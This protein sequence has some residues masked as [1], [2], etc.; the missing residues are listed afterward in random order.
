MEV[1]L[2]NQWV[3][4]AAAWKQ[5]LS[6]L[7]INREYAKA[8]RRYG[9]QIGLPDAEM[10]DFLRW[11][12]VELLSHNQTESTKASKA[13]KEPLPDLV[14]SDLDL[15]EHDKAY[16]HDTTRNVYVVHLPSRKHPLAIPG[17]T[18][19]AIR[20][21]YS[22]WSGSPASINEIARKFGMARRTVVELLRVMGTTHDSA[23]WTEET[24]KVEGEQVL[25]EDLLRRKEERI[26]VAS[27]RASWNAVKDDAN[28]WRNLR[29]HVLDKLAT[30]TPKSYKVRKL[31]LPQS[32]REYV[33]IVSPTDF[34]FGKYADDFEV[35]MEDNRNLQRQRLLVSTQ[36]VMGDVVLFGRPE[37][38]IVGV[39]SDFFNIDND[40]KS[41]TEGT[42]QDVDGNPAEIMVQ[43][44]RLMVEYIDTLRQIA[45]VQLVLMSGN[46]DRMMGT[47]M[48][49]YLE[50]WYRGQT[51]VMVRV[52]S[53]SPR[54]YIEYGNNLL[55]FHH[56]DLVNKTMDLARLAATER[57]REW[58]NCDH[59]MV[60]TGHLHYTKMEDDRGFTRF[61]LPSL[62]GADRWHHRNGYVGAKRQLAAVLVDRMAG[63]FGTLYADDAYYASIGS[64]GNVRIDL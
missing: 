39:G 26:L 48:L 4:L 47:M 30:L 53:A 32:L 8:Q 60:F 37:R 19:T 21:A 46:H 18:W 62:S 61:Q 49:M 63:V 6:G 42:P 23:P 58:G 9:S 14:E 33:A 51:D 12:R 28:K 10:Y 35:D 56:A 59:R 3:S 7:V 44:C 25:T 27:E 64:M 16:W 45:P 55:C 24:L 15:P 20:E 41:T 17:D 22:N 54:Q 13:V 40:Q 36:K 38:I 57:P 29:V 2:H 50:A 34:H 1:V 31:D 5:K 52:A 11:L 43:G